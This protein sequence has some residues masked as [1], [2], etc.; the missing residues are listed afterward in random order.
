MR[1]GVVVSSLNLNIIKPVLL[2]N[3]EGHNWAGFQRLQRTP[4]ECAIVPIVN[5]LCYGPQPI[6]STLPYK[7]RL[8]IIRRLSAGSE[9]SCT[10]QRPQPKPSKAGS[11]VRGNRKPGLLSQ[12][13]LPLFQP[14]YINLFFHQIV[15]I[16]Y[17][18]S[19]PH[20][21]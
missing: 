12:D 14:I 17:S 15:H 11:P 5:L 3:F 4:W 19:F 2:A 6:V 9:D 16:L 1:I 21:I 10:N 18:F 20:L 8:V 13:S 7:E